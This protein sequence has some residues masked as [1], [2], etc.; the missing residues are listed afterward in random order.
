MILN[1]LTDQELE[2]FLDDAIIELQ[3]AQKVGKSV[4]LSRVVEI[5]H[6]LVIKQDRREAARAKAK[7][8]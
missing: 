2:K 5:K 4:S 6:A 1:N 7:A 8:K 3:D